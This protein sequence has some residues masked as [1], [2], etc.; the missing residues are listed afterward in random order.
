MKMR[1]GILASVIFLC[2]GLFGAEINHKNNDKK[3]WEREDF[4]TSSEGH[5]FINKNI[6]KETINAFSEFA[7]QEYYAAN[8]G[9][10]KEIMETICTIAPE[11]YELHYFLGEIYSNI[12]IF[13][14]LDLAKRHYS[15]FTSSSKSRKNNFFQDAASKIVD[16]TNDGEEALRV[17]KIS[18]NVSVSKKSMHTMYIANKKAYESTGD[19]DYK[20]DMEFFYAQIKNM[21]SESAMETEL[22][23]FVKR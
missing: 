20:H 8:Y 1:L 12:G 21:F 6:S 16:L 5:I 2:S 7:I 11:H 3:P 23:S 18:Y 10:S 15:T 14:N 22:D 13:K 4:V 9:S 19:L 17:A